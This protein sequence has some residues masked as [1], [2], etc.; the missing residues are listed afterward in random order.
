[1]S[2]QNASHIDASQ[3]TFYSVGRDQVNNTTNHYTAGKLEE[4]ARVVGHTTL[5]QV[6]SDLAREQALQNLS[7][8]PMD[9]SERPECLPATRVDL[10]KSILDWLVDTSKTENMLWLHG[11]A[12]SGKSTLATTIANALRESGHLG[13]FLFFDRDITEKSDPTSVIRTLAYQLGLFNPGIASEIAVVLEKIPTICMSP[14]RLQFFKLIVEPL[15]KWSTLR[16]GASLVLVIDALDECGN[17]KQ[18][19]LL[20]SVLAAESCKLPTG[21]RVLVTSR[22][23]FDIRCAFEDEPN[24]ISRELDITSKSNAEDILCYL[25]IRMSGI[26]RKKR[27][28]HLPE[29]WPGEENIWK[30]SQLASGLFIWASTAS[31]FIDGHDPVKRLNVLLKADTASNA[32]SALDVLY[33]TALESAGTWDDAEF[34]EDFRHILGVI[35]VVMHPLAHWGVDALLGTA[36]C[37]PSMHTIS[38]LACVLS[39]KPTV[40]VLHPSFADFLTDRE[41]CGRD[42]WY[43][44]ANEH[45]RRVAI[46]CLERLGKT[47]KRNICDL[48]LEPRA[49]RG[50]LD[51]ISYSCPAWVEHVCTV[52]KDSKSIVEHVEIFLCQHLLHWLEATS[53]LCETRR[54]IVLLGNLLI[55]IKVCDHHILENV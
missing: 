28:L 43:I 19:K 1:M 47:L 40:R 38:L 37:R 17:A 51:D 5:I 2:F 24:I 44:D 26:R 35:L 14:I 53:I 31:E 6:L 46:M 9:A 52:T 11:L 7:P 21:I 25:R 48:T 27:Y 30:L 41:R 45:H 34:V 49:R 10:V 42:I 54:T 39:Q 29:N 20:L 22:A 32:E 16:A 8:I 18:R 23:E 50:N 3:G 4:I 33:R 13:A 15:L 36:K 55:W 12:G